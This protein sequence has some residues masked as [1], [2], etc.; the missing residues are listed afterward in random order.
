MCEKQGLLFFEKLQT[1]MI[2]LPVVLSLRRCL[3][4]CDG[5]L[6]VIWA[7]TETPIDF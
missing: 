7:K 1:L 4:F 2:V 5:L 6:M 3:L